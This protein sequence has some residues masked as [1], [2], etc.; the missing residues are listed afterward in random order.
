MNRLEDL[1]LN[2]NK[3]ISFEQGTFIPCS[4]T[5][6]MLDIGNNPI[7]NVSSILHNLPNKLRQ[8]NIPCEES[9]KEKV[10]KSCPRL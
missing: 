8:L 6:R 5:L 9:D 2:G 4:R 10:K 7:T 3:I 1:K